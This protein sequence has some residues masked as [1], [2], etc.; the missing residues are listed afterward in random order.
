[1]A[2]ATNWRERLRQLEADEA[3]QRASLTPAKT[4]ESID[5]LAVPAPEP[6]NRGV[7]APMAVL[8]GL[9]EIETAPADESRSVQNDLA[10]VPQEWMVGLRR[11][12]AAPL[13][14]GFQERQWRQ[15]IKDARRFLD[16]HGANAVAAGCGTLDIFGAHPVAPNANYSLSGLVLLI[17]GGEVTSI[18]NDRAT[19]RSHQGT[20]LSYRRCPMTGAVLLWDLLPLP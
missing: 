10:G 16:T 13:I 15:V 7:L 11:L 4:A 17:S 5:L 6:E 8:A 12:E 9:L 2:A 18:A 14:A 1:M 3:D 20:T 19:I